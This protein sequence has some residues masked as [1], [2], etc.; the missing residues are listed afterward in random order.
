M[1]R[2]LQLWNLTFDLLLFCLLWLEQLFFSNVSCSDHLTFN[3]LKLSFWSPQKC[4]RPGQHQ[5]VTMSNRT[6]TSSWGRLSSYRSLWKRSLML[7]A[8][9]KRPLPGAGASPVKRTRTDGCSGP[10][11]TTE[12]RRE[13]LNAPTSG[14]LG[15]SDSDLWEV[16]SGFCSESSP[17]ASG[18]SSP[19][20]PGAVVALDCEMVGTGP[21]GRCSELARCS[22][23]DYHGNVLYDK[24]VL[25]CH[26]VTDFRTRWSGISRHH[27][28]RAIAFPQARD[29]VRLRLHG[30]GQ[31]QSVG[32]QLR[33]QGVGH[34]E[35]ESVND[36]EVNNS[37]L[38]VN[39]Q[40]NPCYHGNYHKTS[41]IFP[42]FL[43]NKRLVGSVFL[44]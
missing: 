13:H 35:K 38:K 8:S 29:E 31:V 22:I 32:S 19:C 24:Y 3:E 28:D 27:L 15:S 21:A 43:F 40:E 5:H 20:P 36:C 33:S 10:P 9:R 30:N 23:L 34:Q 44:L 14:S 37:H 42:T 1:Y 18:R 25:P 17:P 16:D 12:L 26:P 11:V 6:K 7:R 39:R 2:S 41:T 4:R